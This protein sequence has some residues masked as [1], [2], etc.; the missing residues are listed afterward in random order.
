MLWEFESLTVRLYTKF[1]VYEKVYIMH[2]ENYRRTWK[3]F[4]K[5]ISPHAGWTG[6]WN[7]GNGRIWKRRLSKARR[8]AWKD[9]HQRGLLDAERECNWKCW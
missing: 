3:E 4:G 7:K 5:R 1:V 6:R 9:P 2:K 8:R